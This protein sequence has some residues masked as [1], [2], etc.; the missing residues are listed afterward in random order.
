VPVTAPQPRFEIGLGVPS[1]TFD[2]LREWARAA[3]ELGFNFIAVGDNPGQMRDTYV[4][5]T[6][7]AS[8]TKRCRVGTATTNPRHR[9]VLVTASAMSS[10]AEIA[11]DRTFIGLGRGRAHLA[12]SVDQLRRAVVGLR[13]LWQRGETEVDGRRVVLDWDARPVPIIVAASGPRVLQLAGE[14]ADG[15]IIESGVSD[16]AIDY[17]R[18]NLAAGAA[19]SGRDLA[20]LETWWYLKASASDDHDAA[21]SDSLGPTVASAA[22]VL[23]G[24]PA[25]RGV[26]E[27]FWAGCRRLHE[28]YDMSAH[29]KT[30]ADDPNRALLDDEDLRDY[31]SDRFT[32]AGDPQDWIDR[33]AQLRARGVERL[34]AV[35]VVPDP[36]ELIRT[37]GTQVLPRLE[38]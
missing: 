16:E 13:D 33:I 5:L 9:D 37:V 36:G 31:L 1:V 12:S 29:L 6:L 17:A 8:E 34:Y 32:I 21:I 2:R 28:R 18:R 24:D 15:V 7:L 35:G 22:L 38:S 19:L 14:L 3:D 27:R 4:A 25:K 26:P 23:G 20:S 30:G 11:P 10:I